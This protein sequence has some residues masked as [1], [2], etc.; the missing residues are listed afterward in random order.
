MPNLTSVGITSGIP[1]SGTGTVST[2]DAL[3]A[4]GLPVTNA[5][6]FA[7]QA[8]NAA[9]TTKVI[10]TVRIADAA[11]LATIKAA[12]TAPVVTDT[13]LVVAIS[14]NSVNANGSAISSASAPV[15]IASDQAAVQIKQTKSATG[16]QS[17][18][19]SSATDV[20]ILA[21]NANR[22]GASVY[23]DSTQILY[24]LLSNATSSSTVH[25]VQVGVGAYFEVPAWY[26][27]VLKGL[28]VS[29]NGSARVTEFT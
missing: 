5:G 19:A 14:P 3:M 20:T 6:T 18:V 25:S 4:S 7:V 10:G 16:T 12:S 29:A 2:I 13:A 15:V 8:T 28:W 24:L 26:T 23:N 9:E 22:L 11:S 1:T 17:I 27:G 21:S